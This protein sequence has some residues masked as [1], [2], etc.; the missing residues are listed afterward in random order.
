[1][2]GSSAPYRFDVLAQLANIP[3]RITLY[4]LLR[5]SK[6]TREALREAL[7]DAEVFMVWILAEPHEKDEE[8]Y[9]RASQH[10][11]C[12]TITPDD[13]QVKGKHDR[14]LYFTGYILSLIHI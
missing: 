9:L 11:P 13:M 7:A 6:S 2:E 12:I 4:E 10:A 5:L 1:M 8:D 3:A 14:L